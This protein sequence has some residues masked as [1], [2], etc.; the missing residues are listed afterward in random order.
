MRA[1]RKGAACGP[2]RCTLFCHLLAGA[3]RARAPA[4]WRTGGHGRPRI[5]RCPTAEVAHRRSWRTATSKRARPRMS[6]RALRR[7]R[8]RRR[9]RTQRTRAILHRSCR[10]ATQGR[11]TSCKSRSRRLQRRP[12]ARRTRAARAARA[13]RTAERLAPRATPLRTASPPRRSS[14]NALVGPSGCG[15]TGSSLSSRPRS[16]RTH[17]TSTSRTICR[18]CRRV[19]HATWLRSAG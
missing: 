19:S 10:M 18:T 3:W 13:A 1:I 17:T 6:Q 7:S 5:L 2:R 15:T 8:A 4:T 14:S 16:M 9:L 12:R 11:I